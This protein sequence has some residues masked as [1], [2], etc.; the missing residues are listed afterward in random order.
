MTNA[1]AMVRQSIYQELAYIAWAFG[2]ALFAWGPLWFGTELEGGTRSNSG[3]YR[4]GRWLLCPPHSH[5]RMESR[6]AT[7]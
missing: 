5:P 3:S 6:S 2:S 7:V 1:D 4:S